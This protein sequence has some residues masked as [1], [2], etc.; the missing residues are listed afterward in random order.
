M[1]L[2]HELFGAAFPFKI[3]RSALTCSLTDFGILLTSH[4]TDVYSNK[5]IIVSVLFYRQTFMKITVNY[6]G[7]CKS[8]LFS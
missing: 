8:Q 4:D 7:T 1:Q 2:P 6:M 5:N 3:L